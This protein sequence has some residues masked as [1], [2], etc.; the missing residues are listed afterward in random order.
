MMKEISY[1]FLGNLMKTNDFKEKKLNGMLPYV[2]KKR[3]SKTAEGRGGGGIY[4]RRNRRNYRVIIQ[5]KTWNELIKT[6][7]KI[8]DQYKE[9]YAILITPEEYFGSDDDI[10]TYGK[11][12][13]PEISEIFNKDLDF[14]RTNFNNAFIYYSSIEQ[15]KK[16]EPFKDKWK[17]VYELATSPEDLEKDWVGHYA[18][19]IKN[20][21]NNDK[22]T[23]S[24]ICTS[25]NS[26]VEEYKQKFKK[27]FPDVPYDEDNFP[28]QRGLGNFDFD[29]A[30]LETIENVKLQMEYLILSSVSKNDENFAEYVI[31]HFEEFKHKDETVT[32]K[33][34]MEEEN[35]EQYKEKFS[36]ELNKLKSFCKENELLDYDK[37]TELGVWNN[38][39]N[40]IICP[41]CHK[42]IYL[43]QFFENVEQMKG[44]E[45]IDNTQKEIVL[46][47]I[48]ALAPGKFNHR[49]YNL[50][51]GHNY[52]N[53]IQGDRDLN[54]T[55]G[56]LEDIIQKYKGE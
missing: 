56:I 34:W 43:N 40:H 8:L 12:N 28:K 23:M 33:K 14:E 4:K 10:S 26:K 30:N 21:T 55:I 38:E 25:G 18:S 45:V 39:K 16:Y 41:L 6:N 32:F 22:R 36:E 47:H 44:R 50:G 3:I 20:T 52:C 29:Y 37:L 11:C 54:E 27:D 53:L 7:P 24:D 46:M 35:H 17:P 42:Q 2:I 13:Y 1:D 19:N 9:G 31:N 48:E 5:Y 49:P 15:F 51:W